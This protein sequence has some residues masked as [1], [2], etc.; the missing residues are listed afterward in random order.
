MSQFVEYAM[1]I[2]DMASGP[3]GG[4][5]NSFDKVTAYANKAGKTS[6]MFSNM[7]SGAFSLNN[8]FGAAQGIINVAKGV[9]ESIGST[10][11][12]SLDRQQLQVSFDVF[13]ALLA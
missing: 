2:K 13:P 12:A 7:V 4:I 8:I 9:G 11:Q 10:I 3:L 5:A 6:S 1:K